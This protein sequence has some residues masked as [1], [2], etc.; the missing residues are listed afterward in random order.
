MQF[1]SLGFLIFLPVVAMFNYVI[2][3]KYRYIWLL[4]TS[5]AFYI[6]VDVK[7]AAVMAA[8]SSGVMSLTESRSP[9]HST[10]VDPS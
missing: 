4:V 10:F 7:S 8:S 2:P 5:L 6:S 1:I 3:R 9:V